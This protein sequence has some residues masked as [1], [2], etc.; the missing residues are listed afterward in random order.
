MAVDYILIAIGAVTLVAVLI[1]LGLSWWHFRLKRA[2][3]AALK[4]VHLHFEVYDDEQVGVHPAINCEHALAMFNY[5]YVVQDTPGVLGGITRCGRPIRS[6]TSHPA[7]VEEYSRRPGAGMGVYTAKS[8]LAYDEVEGEYQ[9]AECWQAV[10]MVAHPLVDGW[11][12]CEAAWP[13]EV[14]PLP[15]YPTPLTTDDLGEDLLNLFD[16]LGISVIEYPSVNKL[17][18]LKSAIGRAS[19]RRKRQ[20]G[21]RSRCRPAP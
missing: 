11:G 16:E 19:G 5:H 10:A 20:C 6:V 18:R 21:H 3:R 4:V 17:T 7:T 2:E 8:M 12:H 13:T 9:C 1:G 15:L 14:T